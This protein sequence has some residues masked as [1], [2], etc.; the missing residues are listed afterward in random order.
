MARLRE[1]PVRT[2]TCG[3][4]AR[5]A[6]RTVRPAQRTGG[7]ML[8]SATSL[9]PASASHRCAPVSVS[10]GL[11]PY[12][13]R[14]GRIQ[15]NQLLQPSTPLLA[16]IASISARGGGSGGQSWPCVSFHP[17]ARLGQCLIRGARA[18]GTGSKPEPPAQPAVPTTGPEKG[19]EGTG[20]VC[21]GLAF[22]FGMPVCALAN[23]AL[24][25]NRDLLQ[26]A[27]P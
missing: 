9:R 6:W 25:C 5:R 14:R 15:K 22:S 17:P 10:D 13:L 4:A 7:G 8:V 11:Q 26:V 1:W 3:G 27:D 23:G 24:P 19:G 12:N 20:S 16:C 2:G 18:R 21:Q